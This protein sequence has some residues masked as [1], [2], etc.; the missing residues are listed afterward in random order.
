MRV[1]LI[2]AGNMARAIARGWGDPVLCSDAGSGRAQALVDELGGEAFDSNLAV[3]ERADLVVL[4]HKPVQ[5]KRVATEIAG[6]AKVVAS[7][8]GATSVGML[9]L[10]YPNTP[11]FRLMPNTPVEVRRGIICYTPPE[12]GPPIQPVDPALEREV[13]ALFE[14]LGSVVRVS[15][16]LLDPAAAVMSVGPAYQALLAEAQVDAAV[17]Y[18][19]PAPLAGRL[20]AETMSGTAELLVARNYDTLAVRR[21]VTSPGGSTARGLAALEHGRIRDAFQGAID[22]V[23]LGGGGADAGGNR[24]LRG[25]GR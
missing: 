2:G 11:V 16:E 6:T 5:L 3:A 21:E 20:V 8:L 24:R 19:L 12:G 7:V 25:R 4:C 22:A 17:R 13:L 9:Q 14:R 23:V 15:E 18:G 1:G 10:A